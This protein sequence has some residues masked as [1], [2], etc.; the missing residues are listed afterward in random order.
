MF[1]SL[2]VQKAR[3]EGESKLNMLVIAYFAARFMTLLSK[4]YQP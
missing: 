4:M 3:L 2:S 1:I